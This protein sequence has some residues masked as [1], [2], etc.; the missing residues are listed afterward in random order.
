MVAGR[1]S[2]MTTPVLRVVVADDEPLSLERLVLAFGDIADAEIVGAAT[3][4]LQALQMIEDLKPDLAVLDI[5]MPGRTGLGV[6]AALP[7][8]G[9]PEI[10][11]LTAFDSHAVDAF[12]VDAADYVLKPLRLER[13]RQAVERA[14]RRRARGA[15]P[16]PDSHDAPA[17]DGFW[18]QGRQG[19]VRVP[20]GDIDWIEAAKDYVLL[21]TPNRSHMLRATMASIEAGFPPPVLLR[22]HRSALV[23]PGAVQSLQAV[24]SAGALVLT[25]G[26]AVPV[27][28]SYW[29]EVS[30]RFRS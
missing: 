9:R 6:A 22:V 27:G 23:R 29:P 17:G 5:Q 21:H 20:L 14:R 3:N 11:F 13:L 28:P 18:V 26:V 12:D 1:R 4:G 16:A 15:P 8:D 10:V 2:V 7:H 19:L 30:R 25:H 24:G